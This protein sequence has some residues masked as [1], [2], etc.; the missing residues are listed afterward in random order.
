MS[1]GGEERKPAGTAAPA[2]P[3][4][5]GTSS[6][7]G[8]RP[9]QAK[10]ASG[11]A[12]ANRGGRGERDSSGHF[13]YYGLHAVRAALQNPR[14]TCHLLLATR[15]ALER[16]GRAVERPGLE[17]RIVSPREVARVLPEGATHQGVALKLAPLPPVPLE[18]ILAIQGARSLFLMLDQITDPRNMGAI[19]RTAVA[20][21]VNAVVV[22]ERRSAELNGAC[23]RAAA[24]AVDMIPVVEVVNLTRA[25]LR[26]KEAGYRVTGLDAEA[27][28]PIETLP[29]SPRRVLVFGSEGSGIRR[30]VGETC[31]ELARITTDPRMESLNVSVA[32]GIALYVVQRV[33]P[34][35]STAPAPRPAEAAT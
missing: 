26:L 16:L 21:G 11:H 14:R 15:Q 3:G 18:R 27:P 20:M 1:A 33:L 6:G 24:G 25:L 10:R 2:R 7:Q 30:L 9:A 28:T 8:A 17:I 31:D 23:A 35:T 34:R 19:L 32:A 29:D 5:G 4:G 13:W 22:Q 12:P